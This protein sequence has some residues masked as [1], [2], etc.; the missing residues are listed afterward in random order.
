MFG[1]LVRQCP[2][3]HLGQNF[4]ISSNIL[5]WN[6]EPGGNHFVEMCSG[7]GPM[8]STLFLTGVALEG[9]VE[10][11]GC[12]AFLLTKRLD[13]LAPT[14][15]VNA[16]TFSIPRFLTNQVLGV[17]GNIPFSITKPLLFSVWNSCPAVLWLML[18]TNS[19]SLFGSPPPDATTLLSFRFSSRRSLMWESSYFFPR[20]SSD[21]STQ[22]LRVRFRSSAKRGLLQ[23]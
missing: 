20:P 22:I 9:T 21:C 13:L 19:T 4:L 14:F 5:S 11:D 1:N 18:H 8:T 3:K 12:L 6:Y 16:L 10:L 23:V 17:A 15:S 7:Y 2:K